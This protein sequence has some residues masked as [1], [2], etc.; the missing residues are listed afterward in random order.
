[1]VANEVIM[2]SDTSIKKKWRYKRYKK[3]LLP[4]TTIKSGKHVNLCLAH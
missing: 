4:V 2:N 1:M 3:E